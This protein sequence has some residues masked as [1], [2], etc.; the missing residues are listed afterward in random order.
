MRLFSMACWMARRTRRL[1]PKGEM[2][3]MV[4]PES[5]RICL[6]PPPSI[7]LFRNSISFLH[8]G[9]AGLPL[10]ADVNVLGVF[11]EDHDVHALGMLH[12]EGTPGK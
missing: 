3:L 10:D 12:G 7:S 9:R 2:G 6:G 1:V 5:V 8:F 4:M 11:A